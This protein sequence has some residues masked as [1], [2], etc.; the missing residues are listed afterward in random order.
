MVTVRYYGQLREL[1]GADEEIVAIQPAIALYDALK[2]KYDFPLCR[3][4]VRL[5]VNDAFAPWDQ[6]LAAGDLVVFIPPVAGG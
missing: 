6:E 3:S 2:A 1:A 5:A 4:H